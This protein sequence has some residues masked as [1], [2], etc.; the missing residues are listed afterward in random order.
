MILTRGGN[1]D[2]VLV[3]THLCLE[4]LLCGLGAAVR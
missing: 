2:L 4:G 1:R 3:V